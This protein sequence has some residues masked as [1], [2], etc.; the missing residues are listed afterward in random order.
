M[1][2]KIKSVLYCY[3][4]FYPRLLSLPLLSLRLVNMRWAIYTGFDL[5][6]FPMKYE[7]RSEIGCFF[8]HGIQTRNYKLQ[9]PTDRVERRKSTFTS[10]FLRNAAD[11]HLGIIMH[12]CGHYTILLKLI[13]TGIHDR[14]LRLITLCI[15]DLFSSKKIGHGRLSERINFD[16]VVIQF[17]IFRFLV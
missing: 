9:R 13:S 6:P 5:T 11:A 7:Q 4:C 15:S 12:G 1:G 14:L 16:I 2:E 17:C 3:C 10:R 8:S